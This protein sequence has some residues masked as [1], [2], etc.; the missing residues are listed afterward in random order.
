MEFS[1]N[2]QWS[3]QRAAEN[4]LFGDIIPDAK[5]EHQGNRIQEILILDDFPKGDAFSLFGALMISL[6][7][8]R[9][10]TY[11]SKGITS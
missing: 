6:A 8:E 7:G 9:A 4:L 5:K 1:E 2:F 10:L 3:G 11:V